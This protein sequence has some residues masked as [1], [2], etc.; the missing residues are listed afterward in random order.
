MVTCVTSSGS[1]AL[2]AVAG[3]GLALILVPVVTLFL[4]W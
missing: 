2:L 4:F 1:Q 3:F